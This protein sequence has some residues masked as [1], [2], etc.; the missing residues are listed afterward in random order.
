[1]KRIGQT[2]LKFSYKR[3]IDRVSYMREHFL[4]GYFT[5]LRALTHNRPEGVDCKDTILSK[6]ERKALIDFFIKNVIPYRI[7]YDYIRFP[8]KVK[9][10]H[11]HYEYYDDGETKEFKYVLGTGATI[12]EAALDIFPYEY[13]KNTLTPLIHERLDNKEDKNYWDGI[14]KN[15]I[16]KK[17]FR[18]E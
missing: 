2:K 16:L 5:G 18:N 3:D 1:M 8:V 14:L 7:Q 10:Y 4:N 17:V 12:A 15:I 11:P 6:K 9:V 13:I